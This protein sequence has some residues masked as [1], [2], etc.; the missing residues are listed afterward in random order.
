[1]SSNSELANPNDSFA[2]RH[3]GDDPGDTAAMLAELGYPTV[4]AR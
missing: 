4:D 3:L 2:R 1:M